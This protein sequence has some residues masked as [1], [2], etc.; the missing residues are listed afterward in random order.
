MAST[1]RL[2]CPD[3]TLLT[4]GRSG[5]PLQDLR[6]DLEDDD[7]LDDLASQ[8]AETELP[9]RLVFNCSGRLHGRDLA[10]EKRLRQVQRRQLSEQ[11]SIN[12]IAPVLLAKAVE[13]L[14]RR[15]QPFH[16]A[17]LSARVGSITDNRLSLIH[18]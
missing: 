15:D 6:L 13:P 7:F 17:S 1:L 16:F 3:L 4:A 18:I 9:L 14:L 10:P 12:A 8:L 2:R 5:P 11:F